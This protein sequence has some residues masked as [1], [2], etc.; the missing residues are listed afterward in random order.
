MCDKGGGG[1]KTL[2]FCVTSFLDGPL[3]RRPCMMNQV[4]VEALKMSSSDIYIAPQ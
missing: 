3:L 1:P 4:T 2:T